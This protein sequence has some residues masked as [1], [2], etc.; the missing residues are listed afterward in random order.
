MNGRLRNQW[1]LQQKELYG[2]SLYLEKKENNSVDEKTNLDEFKKQINNCQN[3]KLS[4]NRKNIVFGI[5]NPDAD[6]V[7]IGMAPNENEELIGEPIVGAEGELFDNILKAINL[8]RKNIYI[9]NILKCKPPNNINIQ[10]NEIDQCI[11]YLDTQLNLINPKL[12]IVLGEIA[13]QKLLQIDIS[14]NEMRKNTYQYNGIEL[15]VTYHP[16]TLINNSK[17]KRPAWED[18]KKMRTKYLK[19]DKF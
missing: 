13:G 2:D 17:L 9:L 4:L 19:E 15:M 5:G 16:E 3:C 12:I 6:L 10:Q 11:P 14:L 7:F 18:F 1:L 8:N